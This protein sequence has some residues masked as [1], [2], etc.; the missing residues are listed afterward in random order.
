MKIRVLITT[1]FL[2]TSASLMAATAKKSYRIEQKLPLV[3]GGTVILD[4]PRG[5]VWIVGSDEPGVEALAIKSVWGV[6]EAWLETGRELTRVVAGGGEKQRVF[7]T[8][9]P[10]AISTQWGSEVTWRLKVPR[11]THVRVI[12]SISRQVRVSN[13]GSSVVVRNFTGN[14]LLENAPGPVQ[15]ESVNGSILYTTPKPQAP[16]TLRTLNGDVTVRV[17]ADADLRWIAETAKGDIRTN[18]PARGTFVNAAYR[19]SVNAP[20]GPTVTTVTLMGHVHLI[21]GRASGMKSVKQEPVTVLPMGGRGRVGPL[22]PPTQPQPAVI[23][24]N[25]VYETNLGDVAVQEVRGSANVFTGAGEVQI[26]GIAGEG[27]IIS[28]GGPLQLGEV[29]GPLTAGTKAGDIFVDSAAR[30]GT[31]STDGGT[32]RLLYT[33]GPTELISGGGDIIVRQADGAVSA[34]TA[35]GDISLTMDPDAKTQKVF[36]ATR[37]GNV[38]LNV[39]P[40]FGAEVEAVIVTSDPDANTVVSQLSGL[41]IQKEQIGVGK[42]RVRASGRIGEGGQRV[43]LEATDGSIRILTAGTG[44]TVVRR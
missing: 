37:K 8:V 29:L 28:L 32:I 24:G 34:R 36:A 17:D 20:G 23:D 42:T 27:K 1:A 5:D 39:S 44:P 33:G 38:V 35:S 3:D 12:S 43:R 7:R 41:T 13:I 19:G 6:D 22:M 25:W 10:Q 11:S 31:F 18:L 14:V 21:G 16:I 26:G 30:G 4:N 2:L 40:Q 15:V 9:L